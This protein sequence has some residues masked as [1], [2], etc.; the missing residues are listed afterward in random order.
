MALDGTVPF[1]FKA[2][3][4]SFA[5]FKEDPALAFE[6]GFQGVEPATREQEGSS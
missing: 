2:G 4:N 3:V 5:I 6:I 1:Q